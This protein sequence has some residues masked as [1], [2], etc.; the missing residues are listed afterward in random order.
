MYPDPFSLIVYLFLR[1]QRMRLFNSITDSMDMNLN[2]LWE[3][4][5]DREAWHAAV[6]GFSKSETQLSDQTATFLSRIHI[7][8]VV[9][10]SILNCQAPFK[11]FYIHVLQKCYLLKTTK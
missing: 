3:V 5:K 6:S 1:W 7:T 10:A 2:K 8:E 9:F 11:K 4:V